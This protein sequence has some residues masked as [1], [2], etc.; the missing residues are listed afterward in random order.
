MKTLIVNVKKHLEAADWS[1]QYSHPH[2]WNSTD[3]DNCLDIL[4]RSTFPSVTISELVDDNFDEILTEWLK[5]E[6]EDEFSYVAAD[7]IAD[8]IAI[9]V[10][11]KR[12]TTVFPDSATFSII[13]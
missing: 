7:L 8:L 4:G 11:N 2:K 13:R 12:R 6:G 3:M 9:K 1:C 5:R 10:L